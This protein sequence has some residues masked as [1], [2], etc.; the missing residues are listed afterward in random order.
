MST[1]YIPCRLTPVRLGS[2]RSLYRSDVGDVGDVGLHRSC[3]YLCHLHHFGGWSTYRLRL[4]TL[5]S[6]LVGDARDNKSFGLGVDIR[7]DTFV[8]A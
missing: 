7:V 6:V 4:S 1:T 5:V 8:D 2:T 3:V